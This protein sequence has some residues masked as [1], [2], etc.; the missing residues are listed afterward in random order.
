MK[1]SL[2]EFCARHDENLD[3]KWF[4]HGKIVF[5]MWRL[6]FGRKVDLKGNKLF[7]NK[8]DDFHSKKWLPEQKKNGYRNEDW[9]SEQWMALKQ[10]K[11]IFEWK[12]KLVKNWYNKLYS[13]FLD[14]KKK[15]EKHRRERMFHLKI[16][17]RFQSKIPIKFMTSFLTFFF[18]VFQKKTKIQVKIMIFHVT[19]MKPISPEPLFT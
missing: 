14:T 10:K 5:L 7:L 8:K 18:F 11:S 19:F 6:V 13:F 3:E 2:A 4:L 12:I 1:S 17:N 16:Q 9:F 15:R